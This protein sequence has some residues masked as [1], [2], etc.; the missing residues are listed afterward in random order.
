MSLVQFVYQPLLRIPPQKHQAPDSR[1]LGC[2]AFSCG[3][4]FCLFAVSRDFGLAYHAAAATALGTRSMSLGSKG[5][6]M[7]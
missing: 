7:M 3:A 5:L 1:G 6:G 2:F 4:G